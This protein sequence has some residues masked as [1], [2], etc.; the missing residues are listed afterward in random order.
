MWVIAALVVNGWQDTVKHNHLSTLTGVTLLIYAIYEGGSFWFVWT[1][2]PFVKIWYEWDEYETEELRQA[3]IDE[4][5]GR[6]EE[7]EDEDD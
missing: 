3:A 7:E 2:M 1:Q 6:E 4:I 5:W